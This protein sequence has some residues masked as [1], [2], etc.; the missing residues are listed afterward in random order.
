MSTPDFVPGP[1]I[2]P[3]G[4]LLE[5]LNAMA[6]EE[7]PPIVG[8]PVVARFVNHYRLSIETFIGVIDSEPAP[9]S[10][11]LALDEALLGSE[12]VIDKVRRQVPDGPGGCALWLYGVWGGVIPFENPAALADSWPFTVLHI[13][14]IIGDRPPSAEHTHALIEI[15]HQ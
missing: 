7:E 9:D 11:R 3:P 13:G 1:P 4:P 5:W 10:I 15:T 12:I 2:E 14:D 8:L 6:A